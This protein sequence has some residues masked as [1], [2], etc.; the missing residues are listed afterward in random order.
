MSKLINK[1]NALKD[2]G[3]SSQ[4]ANVQQAAIPGQRQRFGQQ[5]SVRIDKP[6]FDVLHPMRSIAKLREWEGH[7]ERAQTA[8][9]NR[10]QEI[11]EHVVLKEI[12][13]TK[14]VTDYL[15]LA[16]E[17][18]AHERARKTIA[19]QSVQGAAQSIAEANRLTNYGSNIVKHLKA[20]DLECSM[21]KH[22]VG[23]VVR[24]TNA[25]VTELEST[26]LGIEFD[27][28][29]FGGEA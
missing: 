24:T 11:R 12:E 14:Q 13:T 20:A 6:K 5:L 19:K 23:M 15:Q 8:E 7:E 18:K 16:A 1:L 21:K 2:A 25:G 3:A 10:E 26:A 22:L 28:T 17:A 4:S 29:L 9:L 27:P